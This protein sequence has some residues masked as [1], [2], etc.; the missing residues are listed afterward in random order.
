MARFQETVRCLKHDWTELSNA[1][2]TEITFEALNVPI[3]VRVTTGAKPTEKVGFSYQAQT[4]ENCISLD[5]I[6]KLPG[7]TR[8]WARPIDADYADVIVDQA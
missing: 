5:Q 8:L 7:A 3:Y 6:S 4:G 2:V 1:D